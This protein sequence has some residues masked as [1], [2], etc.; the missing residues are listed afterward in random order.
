[1][2]AITALVPVNDDLYRES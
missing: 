1:M 2:F